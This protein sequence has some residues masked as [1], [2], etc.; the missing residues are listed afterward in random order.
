MLCKEKDANLQLYGYGIRNMGATTLQ[1]AL[2][3]Y[4]NTATAQKK[5]VTTIAYAEYIFYITHAKWE[6]NNRMEECCV[7]L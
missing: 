5:N 6:L 1:Y 7:V 4:R 2:R 3:Y